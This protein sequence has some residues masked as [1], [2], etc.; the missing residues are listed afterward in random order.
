M[1]N[2]IVGVDANPED[3]RLDMP[4]QVEFEQRGEVAVP[5]LRPASGQASG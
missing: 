3:L 5:V 2:N 1:I 4:L